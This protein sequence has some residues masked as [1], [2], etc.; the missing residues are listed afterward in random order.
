[1]DET[2]R[3]IIIDDSEAMLVMINTML[4]ELGY[5]NVTAFSSPI[6]ALA[7]LHQYPTR[8][9]VVFTDLNM[10]DIDG[11][12]LIRHLGEMHYKGGICI[13]SELDIRIIELAAEV[14]R[15]QYVCLIGNIS[16][17]IKMDALQ[18][19]MDRLHQA[20]ERKFLNYDQ[21]SKKELITYIV[22]RQVMPYYQPKLNPETNRVESL[23]VL[24][25]IVSPGQPDAILPGRFIP[26]AIR[27]DLMDLITMQ[28]AEATADHMKELSHIFG[29][30]V[31]IS[32]NLSPSQLSDLDIPNRLENLFQD[33]N[34]E[35]SRIVLE[36]TEEYELK[37]SEQMES[38]NRLRIHGYGVSLDDFG[39]GFTNIQQLRN[40]PFT[41]VKIDRTLI[42]H[43]HADQFSQVI[44]QSLVGIT[45][46]FDVDLVAEGIEHFEDLDYLTKHHPGILLQGFLI[47]RPKPIESLSSWY[48]N[49]LK[50]VGATVKSV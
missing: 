48:R 28:L 44:V 8:Y 2:I 12:G 46:S 35:K 36:I 40:L 42:N 7:E 30:T 38:L 9:D 45:E 3:I 39:T 24:A 47:C 4:N 43:I 26:T 50:G 29:D 32:I 21:I 13:V 19:V 41:E 33:R 31:K 49:W 10:P 25:R 5:H 27:F 17:P 6:K 1:M 23:E 18:L 34:I 14:A 22:H 37:S 15:Q 20:E 11:M 16:K